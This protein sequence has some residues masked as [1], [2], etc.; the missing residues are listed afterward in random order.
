MCFQCRRP[1]FDSCVRKIP[2]RRK[3]Q[4]T[5]VFLCGKSHGQRSLVGYSPWGHK[6]VHDWAFK[7]EIF[8]VAN[9]LW[10][11]HHLGFCCC[12]CCCC[13]G[14]LSFFFSFFW[15]ECSAPIHHQRSLSMQKEKIKT[16]GLFSGSTIVSMN[17]HKASPLV[18]VPRTRKH[19]PYYSAQSVWLLKRQDIQL[20]SK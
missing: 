18:P 5:P 12:S 8:W 2:W 3:W 20:T 19:M 4:P 1:L 17:S 14:F 15:Y 13:L 11:S 6:V 9:N 16:Q 7:H 10:K